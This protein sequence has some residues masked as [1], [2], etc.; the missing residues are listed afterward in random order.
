MG[1]A[2]VVHEVP[3]TLLELLYLRSSSGLDRVEVPVLSAPP[4]VTAPRPITAGTW[5][6]LWRAEVLRLGARGVHD[7]HHGQIRARLLDAG[8][9]EDALR[10]WLIETTSAMTQRLI[11]RESRPA[12][13]IETTSPMTAGRTIGVLPLAGDYLVVA[14][15]ALILVSEATRRQPDRYGQILDEA[16]SA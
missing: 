8:L 14:G 4:Q 2:T 9:E 5:T 7:P 16:G 1:Q 6:D 13:D 12:I 11:A 3:R 15:P 10:D